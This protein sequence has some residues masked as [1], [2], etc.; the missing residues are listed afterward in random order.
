M[1]GQSKKDSG[2]RVAP[3]LSLDGARDLPGK[4]QEVGSCPCLTEP[5]LPELSPQSNGL[6][7][8]PHFTGREMEAG[9]LTTYLEISHELVVEGWALE[10]TDDCPCPAFPSHIYLAPGS[11]AFCTPQDKPVIPRGALLATCGSEP[12]HRISQMSICFLGSIEMR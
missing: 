12:S 10:L 4:E 1:L 7:Y 11:S 8:H 3:E 9:T 5:F 2:E 6:H